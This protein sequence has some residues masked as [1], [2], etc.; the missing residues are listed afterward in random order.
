M[1]TQKDLL[2]FIS[3]F[4]MCY[5]LWNGKEKSAYMDS[6]RFFR[7]LNQLDHYLITLQAEAAALLHSGLSNRAADLLE[8]LVYLLIGAHNADYY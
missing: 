1:A 2:W 7:A 5:L 6:R 8:D 4:A 3:L